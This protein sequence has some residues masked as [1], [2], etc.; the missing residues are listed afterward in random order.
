M[1]K[2]WSQLLAIL[3]TAILGSPGPLSNKCFQSHSLFFSSQTHHRNVLTRWKTRL[4]LL[5]IFPIACAYNIVFLTPNLPLLDFLCMWLPS[6]SGLCPFLQHNFSKVLTITN[7][8][9]KTCPKESFTPDTRCPLEIIST[10]GPRDPC[11]AALSNLTTVCFF[12]GVCSSLISMEN[13]LFWNF[14]PSSLFLQVKAKIPS[15]VFDII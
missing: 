10:A 3:A 1:M 13:G 4:F 14:L 5:G 15:L 11:L 8:S 12:P 7:N 2:I 6:P 9:M